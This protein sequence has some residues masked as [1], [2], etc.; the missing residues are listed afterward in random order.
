MMSDGVLV[1]LVY[2]YKPESDVRSRS[3]TFTAVQR[4]VRRRSEGRVRAHSS[5]LLLLQSGGHL[6]DVRLAQVEPDGLQQVLHLLALLHRHV[7]GQGLSGGHGLAFGL[8]ED[9]WFGE[10]GRR[11]RIFRRSGLGEGDGDGLGFL[12]PV[13]VSVEKLLLILDAGEDAFI[14]E[15]FQ[16]LS[17][18][19]P[20]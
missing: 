2:N 8:L 12:L 3:D 1:F 20:G 4:R 19:I 5:L 13:F 15:R 14:Q 18:I 7:R 16:L 17:R 6:A 9:G 10:M 11:D